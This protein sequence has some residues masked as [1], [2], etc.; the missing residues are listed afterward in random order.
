MGNPSSWFL[1]NLFTEFHWDASLYLSKRLKTSKKGRGLTPEE[2]LGILFQEGQLTQEAIRLLSEWRVSVYSDPKTARCG[3]DQ[4]S[5]SGVLE[6]LIFENLLP[7][8]G[9]IISPGVHFR[10]RSFG[11]YTKQFCRINRSDRSVSF[12]DILRI[13][14][15][16]TPD[17]RLPGKKEI[18]P[19]WS[20][21]SAAAKELSWWYTSEGHGK[22]IYRS[23]CLFLHWTY[24]EFLRY[25]H[26]LGIEI[27]LPQS[28]GG[29]GY[30]HPE[31]KAKIFSGKTKRMLSIILRND[32]SISH[33]LSSTHLGSIWTGEASGELGRYVEKATK[34]F[35]E[36]LETSDI[37]NFESNL[38]EYPDFRSLRAL[39][40]QV[41]LNTGMWKP[42]QDVVKEVSGKLYDVKS[43]SLRG[44]SINKVPSLASNAR[45]FKAIRDEI[46]SGDPYKYKPLKI[47]SFRELESRRDWKALS[48][49]VFVGDFDFLLPSLLA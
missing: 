48:L 13:R 26:I 45:R 39:A 36:G 49:M 25:C 8:S 5:L 20:R 7:L 30:P 4:I 14:S 44:G 22:R 18:P 24:H 37:R 42:L 33:L 34:E 16:T 2:Q 19:S 10:S 12:V 21:G 35:L 27:F 32:L 29:L 15:L 47:E 40:D 46:L 9:A 28:F 1:L 41:T 6:A 38:P 17:S 31:G 11:I 3:D 23:S 43:F